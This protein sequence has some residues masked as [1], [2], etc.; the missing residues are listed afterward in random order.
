MINI[1]TIYIICIIVITLWTLYMFISDDQSHKIEL[2][3]ISIIE[4]RLRKRKDLINH[5]RFATIP[6]SIPNLNTPRDCYISSNYS[7]IWSEEANRCNQK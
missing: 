4:N 6:C 7:C 3:R 2:E 5:N 1:Q